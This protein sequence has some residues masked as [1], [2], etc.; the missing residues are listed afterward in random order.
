MMA[1]RIQADIRFDQKEMEQF[2]E[3]IAY[4]SCENIPFVQHPFDDAF[5]RMSIYVPEAYFTEG[6]EINGYTKETAPVFFPNA[7]GGYMPGRQEGPGKDHM[8]DYPNTIFRAIQH[9]YVVVSPGV[10][11]RGMKDA[12]GSLTG[13]AP[14]V[15]L[16]L[17]AA[18][19]FVKNHADKIPGNA[20][21]IISNGTSA[22]GAV[23]ALLGASGNHP[24]YEK[25]LRDMGAEEGDD[26]I[27]AASCYCPITNL[28]HAD[29]AYEWEF[30]GLN[31]YHKMKFI[32]PKPGEA[33]PTFEPDDG[34]MSEEQI[35]MSAQLK[36]DFPAYLNSLELRDTDGSSLTLN[37][38]GSGSFRDY[39]G[40]KVLA[41]AQGQLDKGE[42]LSALDWLTIE[43]GRAVS[44]DFTRYTAFRT[45]M[46]TTP[47]F[48]DAKGK[49][50]E[51]ELFGCADRPFRSFTAYGSAHS[52]ADLAPA[53][54]IRMMNAMNYI[55]DQKADTAAYYRIRHG[56]VDRDTSL[57]VSA[58]LSVKLG[59][60]KTDVDFAYPWGMP[61]RGD[62]DLDELFAWIDRICTQDR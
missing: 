49:T 31:E 17:K 28:D 41:S 58:M 46:K 54:Q 56:A 55:E 61:H 57:A 45:R 52:G 6:G 1:D 18:V 3:T 25:L 9:G 13:F 38:D 29:M 50:P 59:N 12:E 26:S 11:G 19:R 5:Q 23:S 40:K 8:H 33:H 32:P 20:R 51:N 62:Y 24:D 30:C 39:V 4:R 15:I 2:G 10:R 14:A 47:A 48:D 60:N 42:D 34:V 22:G 44:M 16:D 21:R 43:D 7:V 27:F 35:R 37:E 53:D 36:A